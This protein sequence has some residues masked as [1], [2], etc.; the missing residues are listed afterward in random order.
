MENR[1]Q[2][3]EKIIDELNSR[4]GF[5]DWWYNI[6]EDTQEEIT[7]TLVNILP[8]HVVSCSSDG[9]YE[10]GSNELRPKEYNCLK[11][12]HDGYCY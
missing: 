12:G 5:D 4:S 11:C 8:I 7:E 6:D 9:C 3:I 1:K 2:L 10:C